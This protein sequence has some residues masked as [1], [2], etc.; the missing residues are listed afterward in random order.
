MK[1][2]QKLL[3]GFLGESCEGVNSVEDSRGQFF[4]HK[5]VSMLYSYSSLTIVWELVGNLSAEI[6]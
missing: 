3:G 4:W 2:E 5:S 6:I 1:Y